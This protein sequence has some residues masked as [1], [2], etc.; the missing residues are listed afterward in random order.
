MYV[1]LIRNVDK[2]EIV[3]NINNIAVNNK[4]KTV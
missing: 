2:T 3:Y 4:Q 1:Y